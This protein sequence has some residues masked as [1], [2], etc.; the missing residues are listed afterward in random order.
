MDTEHRLVVEAL[1]AGRQAA[2][3]CAT[4]ADSS[5]RLCSVWRIRRRDDEDRF[6]AAAAWSRA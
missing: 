1:G 4:G 5:A 3:G 6:V 2:T